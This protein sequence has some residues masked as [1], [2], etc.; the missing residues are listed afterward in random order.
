M[1]TLSPSKSKV[2]RYQAKH[3]LK[4]IGEFKTTVTSNNQTINAK[5][6]VIKGSGATILGRKTAE[7]LDI[8][9]VEPPTT[10]N[11]LSSNQID[12]E[13][14]E[15]F[16]GLGK[17]HNFTLKLHINNIAPVQ[18]P[19]RKIPY[20]LRQ[21]VSDELKQLEN[22]D[23]IEKVHGPI[24]WLNPVVAAPKPNGKFQLCIDMRKANTAIKRERHIIPTLDDI[25]TELH[26][27]TI[28]SK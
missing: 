26:R 7:Q 21:E 27:A 15:L 11:T 16:N 8:L 28:F 25:L 5:F 19:I 24:S 3:S 14:P 13:F 6:L 18:K 17:L 23:V 12:K 22:L 20:H 9:R 4:T 1:S 2:Y 10:V